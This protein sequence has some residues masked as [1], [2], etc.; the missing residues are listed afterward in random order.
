MTLPWKKR[1]L[2][3][4]EAAEDARRKLEQERA[5]W[6]EVMKKTRA[7]RTLREENHFVDTFQTIL[8]GG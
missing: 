4:S 7:I 3:A 6:P 5:K 1:E 8:K 2:E